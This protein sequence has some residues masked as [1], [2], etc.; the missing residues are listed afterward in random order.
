MVLKRDTFILIS[1]LI[2]LLVEG[3]ATASHG[4]LATTESLFTDSRSGIYSVGGSVNLT[5]TNKTWNEMLFTTWEIN[6]NGIKCRIAAGTDQDPHDTCRDGKVLRNTKNGE[7]YLH[8]PHFKDTDEGIY[9]CEMVYQGSTH[10]AHIDVSAAVS[11]QISTRLVFRDGKREAVC[12]A[13]GGKP[14]ASVSWRNTW[15]YNV[16]LSSTENSDGSFT[17]ESRM[18]L[19]ETV[20]ADNLSCIVTHLS[21]RGERIMRIPPAPT[22]AIS[23]LQYSILSICSV[24]LLSGFLAACL[25]VRTSVRRWNN[26]VRRPVCHVY[27]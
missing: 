19:P 22:S 7:S 23:T 10:R 25:I 13:A 11:P 27:R 3:Q 20:S 6:I 16:T 26:K 18:I 24:I 21:W 2:L 4:S 9:T 8:I 15:N 17:V 12:S 14:A 5:C 1:L